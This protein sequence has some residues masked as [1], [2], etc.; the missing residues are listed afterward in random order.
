MSIVAAFLWR[1]TPKPQICTMVYDDQTLIILS[2]PKIYYFSQKTF[3]FRKEAKLIVDEF[4][5][6]LSTL[7][8]LKTTRLI[9]EHKIFFKTSGTFWFIPAKKSQFLYD[10]FIKAIHRL[11]KLSFEV[12][13]KPQLRSRLKG[14][15]L[16][17]FKRE[18][19]KMKLVSRKRDTHYEYHLWALALHATSKTYDKKLASLKEKL[20][21]QFWNQTR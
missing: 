12:S 4:I 5:N 15:P 9:I 16:K 2:A 10:Y 11:K 1:K 19:R 13:L 14:R 6:E 17:I 7:A 21:D 20:L 8:I 18:L 3:S